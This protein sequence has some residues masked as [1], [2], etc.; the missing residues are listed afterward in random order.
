MLTIPLVIVLGLGGLGWQRDFYTWAWTLITVGLPDVWN[1]HVANSRYWQAF[2]MAV[3]VAIGF[4]IPGTI[5]ALGVARWMDADAARTCLIFAYLISAAILGAIIFVAGIIAEFGTDIAIPGAQRRQAVRETRVGIQ[6]RMSGLVMWELII[7]MFSY[8]IGMYAS[9]KGIVLCVAGLVL[10]G[11][12]AYR[13][14]WKVVW[15]PYVASW[16]GLGTTITLAILA[17]V[18]LMFPGARQYAFAWAIDPGRI[19]HTGVVD[20]SSFEQVRR[21]GDQRLRELCGDDALNKIR[22]RMKSADSPSTIRQYQRDLN[23]KEKECLAAS[24]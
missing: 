20:T 22:D 11:I 4:P 19:F 3:K 14:G 2:E 1:D 9:I 13:Y 18:M 23:E 5:L 16:I 24:R 8:H 10:Y 21:V 17:T 12:T 7:F 6:M 15:V